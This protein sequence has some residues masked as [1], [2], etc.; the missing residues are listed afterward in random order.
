MKKIVIIDGQGG[1]LGKAV[2]ERIRRDKLT[3][4]QL[5]AVGTNAVAT[6]T[7]IKAG[8]DAGATGESAIIW[9]CQRADL[10]IGAIG[11]VAAGSM[12]GELNENMALA[13][14][15]AEAIKILIP[16][17]RCHI[18]IAGISE[19]PLAD[20]LDDMAEKIKLYV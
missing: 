8:A 17:N 12:F 20:R 9:N 15:R 2:I 19:Q 11:I 5:I 1:G 4:I 6:S 7:M 10:I 14:G 16:F 18:E 3:D 13:V